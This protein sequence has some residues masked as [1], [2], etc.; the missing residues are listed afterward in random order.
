MVG[1]SLRDRLVSKVTPA[2]V[3]RLVLLLGL[4][5]GIVSWQRGFLE[6]TSKVDANYTV[7]ASTGINREQKF[8]FFLYHLNLFPIGTDAPIK[9]DTADEAKRLMREQPLLLRQDEGSTFREGDRGRTYL[10][11]VD[12]YLH[13]NAL[14]PSLKP[15]HCLAFTLALCALMLSFWSIRRTGA[16][17]FLVLLAGSSPFQLYTVYKQDNVF[18][19]AFTALI[20]GLAVNVPLLEKRKDLSRYYPW[21]AAALTGLLVAFVRNFRSEPTVVMFGAVLIYA[22]A[23]WLRKRTRL[24]LVLVMAA[25]FWLSTRAFSAFTDSKLEQA[26]A[27]VATVGGIP[28][29]GPVRHFH[30]FWHA[31]F[32]GL[33]DF[34]TKYGYVWDDRVA[35]RATYEELHR[36]NP[37]LALDPTQWLTGRSYDPAGKYPV[38]YGETP[39]YEEVVRDYILANIKK[40]PVWFV[41]IIL[42][43]IDR[44]MTTPVPV[45]FANK[46]DQY[47]LSGP[48]LTFSCIPLILFLLVSRRWAHLKIL[49]FALPLSIA[50]IAVYSGLGMTNYSCFHLFGVFLWGLVAWEGIRAMYKR[51][52]RPLLGL[53]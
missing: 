38:F 48:A 2:R 51:R 13:K 18:S 37:D 30:T 12:A 34:D 36:R 16:G 5:W 24:A 26:K 10:Y 21:I 20:F 50:P 47:Y 9:R 42:S 11:F 23:T 49:F 15:A 43:R 7:T 35:Y 53:R 1:S 44:V 14:T 40:D 27:A 8:F 46:T 25:T 32:C 3:L 22:T 29:N 17:L 39:H 45:G 33:G 52:R 28:Y 31:I 41:K 19:W 6:P 4:L